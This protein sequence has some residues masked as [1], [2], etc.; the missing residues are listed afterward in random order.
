MQSITRRGFLTASATTA[1]WTV[2]PTRLFAQAAKVAPPANPNIV[3]IMSDDQ[4]YGDVA[5]NN[6]KAKFKTPGIDRIAREGMR[7]TDAHSPSAVCTPTRYALLTGRYS[8][9]SRLQNAVL[10]SGVPPLIAKDLMTVQRFLKRNGYKTACMGKWHLG[11]KYDLPAGKTIS[12]DRGKKG[13]IPVG[14]KIIE[15]PIERDFDVYRGFHHAGEMR[16]WIEQDRVTENFDHPEKMLPRIAKCSIDYIKERGEK[17][18]GPFFL[19]IPFNSPHGPIVPSK[20]WKGKSKINAHADYV[21]QTDDVVRRIV[22]ALDTAGLAKNTLVVFTTDNGTSPSANLPQLRKAGHDSSGGLR[23][24]KADAWEG[25][26]RVPYVVRWPGTIKPGSVCDDTICHTNLMAT[27]AEI[28]G[29]TLEDNEGVD[30]FS[31]L[32]LLQG[33]ADAAPSHPYVIHHSIRGHFAIRRGKWKFL[34]CKNSGGWAKGGDNKPSQLYNM[35]ADRGEKINLV[36]SRRE[37]AEELTGL[38]EAAIANGRTRPGTPQKNDVPVDLWKKDSEAKVKAKK[39]A[40]ARA[41]A[42]K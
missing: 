25:G 21:M 17:K 29:K 34:A 33:K 22:K 32:G 37:I 41:K 15:G 42:K 39:K 4:G 10:K 23:G 6:K 24:A 31:I 7:F 8:W 13:A 1:A 3:F 5:C 35:K 38:L 28:L 20:E 18:D 27:C 30:S 11:F 2:A 12:K 40:K 36:S 26:H 19:Y 14:S 16:T 9:R